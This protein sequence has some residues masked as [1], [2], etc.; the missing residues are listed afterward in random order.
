MYSESLEQA[1]SFQEYYKPVGVQVSTR[2]SRE[3][4]PDSDSAGKLPDCRQR[5]TSGTGSSR[6]ASLDCRVPEG[7]A[8]SCR[9]AS[10]AAGARMDRRLDWRNRGP[11]KQNNIFIYLFIYFNLIHHH[12]HLFL[13]RTYFPCNAMVRHLSHVWSPSTEF[14]HL[15][16]LHNAHSGC[17]SIF[18]LPCPNISPPATTTF[19]QVNTHLSTPLHL[20]CP[21]HFQLLHLTTHPLHYEP[22]E[23]SSFTL[24]V[25]WCEVVTFVW[26]IS[27]SCGT[28]SPTDAH[29]TRSHCSIHAT[30]G[31]RGFS[32]RLQNSSSSFQCRIQ[33][34]TG[35]AR[36]L[37]CGS[38]GT[39]STATDWLYGNLKYIVPLIFRR[40]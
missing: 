6:G 2:K 39:P 12:H 27:T 33:T 8:A 37:S 15:W 35:S 24:I 26:N 31:R 5:H 40:S 19:L 4:L 36:T 22:P 23:D 38:S 9:T 16:I 11:L 7:A 18:F 1:A 32:G 25:R 28:H 29:M 34:R 30:R 21:N 17:N 10:S 20:K 14:T 3:H 13:K